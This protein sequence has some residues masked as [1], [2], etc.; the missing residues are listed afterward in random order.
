M[1]TPTAGSEAI[2]RACFSFCPT[3]SGKIMT[4]LPHLTL[5]NRKFCAKAPDRTLLLLTESRHV[6]Q[7]FRINFLAAGI[8]SQPMVDE[9]LNG[10]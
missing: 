4:Q 2:H 1:W 7:H 8:C 5:P 6:T 3:R 10:T 9:N